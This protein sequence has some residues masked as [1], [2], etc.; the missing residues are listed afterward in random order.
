MTDPVS[1]DPAPTAEPAPT[2]PASTAEPVMPAPLTVVHLVRHGEVH[3]PGKVLYG[4]LPGFRLS[5]AGERM[6]TTVAEWLSRR[7][8][9]ALYTSPLQ[10]AR[11]TVAPLEARTGLTATVDHRL[12]ESASVFEGTRVE[13]GPSTLLRPSLWRHLTNPLRPSWGEPFADVAARV[14]SVVQE[15]RDAWPGGEVVLVSH[16]LPIWVSRRAVEGRPLWHRPDRRQCGLASVTT[17]YYRAGTLVRLDYTEPAGGGA[18]PGS[19]G[20]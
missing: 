19:V 20:A 7:P 3:N 14:L 15:A 11:E 4:R 1:T 6:A 12:I 2:D 9:V 8:I 10:R 18:G 5:A 16:Q 13:F 17:L